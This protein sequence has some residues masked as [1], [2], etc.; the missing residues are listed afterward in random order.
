MTESDL[1]DHLLNIFLNQP[2]KTLAKV[3]IIIPN[4][5]HSAYLKQR[6]DSVL[7]QTYRDFE[8]IILDDCSCDN[9]R[10]IIEQY[11]H[12]EKIIDIIYNTEN[13]GSTFKQWDKGIRLAEGEYVWLAESDDWCEANLLETIIDGLEK[14]KNCVVGYC[15]SYCV[16]QDNAIKF[17]SGHSRLTD[18]VEGK[19]FIEEYLLPRNPIF[20]A[21]MAVWR[22]DIYNK[23]SKDYINYF[24]IGDYYF[25]IEICKW[26]TVFISGKL[27]NYF[28]THEKNVSFN[29]IKNGKLYI[30]QIPFLK[31]I[32]DR[33]LIS[34]EDY[35]KTLQPLYLAFRS[36]QQEMAKEDLATIKKMFAHTGEYHKLERLF[37]KK[38]MYSFFRRLMKM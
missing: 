2:N 1:C 38:H 29:A 15:Q 25:W 11:R 4:Y 18:Y 8:V 5:N 37:L 17:Q 33:N 23:I 22:R 12:H 7:N 34:K 19:K 24:I 21:G 6:I 32:M 30:E 10:E 28:R 27:L 16:T 14:D 13:S 35:S 9:S 31:H 20:N 36:M 3:S 26:G